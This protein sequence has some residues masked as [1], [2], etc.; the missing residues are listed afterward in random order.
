MYNDK[1]LDVAGGR[2]EEGANVQVYKKNGS[3]A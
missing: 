1:A 3:K 2:D